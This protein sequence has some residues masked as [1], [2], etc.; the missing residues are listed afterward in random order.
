[1]NSST[2]AIMATAVAVCCV[3][4]RVAARQIRADVYASGL[5]LPGRL[6][7]GSVEPHRSVR[8]GTRRPDSRPGRRRHFRNG[9]SRTCQ[10]RSAGAV[11][12]ACLA[13][14]LRQTTAASGRFYRELH[15][16]CRQTR[17]SPASGRSTANPL[18]ADAATR[19]SISMWPGGDRGT[20]R[21]RLRTT[22]A[23]TSRSDQTAICT[24][25]SA[26]DGSP[27]TIPWQSRAESVRTLLGKMLRDRRQRARRRPGRDTDVPRD[28]SVRRRSAR[29]A[30][31]RDLGLRSCGTRG[32]TAS[33]IRARGGTGALMIADVG[34]D[35]WEEIDYEPAGRGG[36][37]YG[38]R[39][40]EGSHNNI[41]HVAACLPAIGRPNRQVQPQR[42]VFGD[43]WLRL[44]WQRTVG[45]AYR[46]RYFY[47]DF[48]A[49][50]VWSMA[51]TINGTTGEATG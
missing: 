12:E 27:A 14:L 1:M 21:S 7:A 23:G 6:R 5:S 36:R 31:A 29:P 24:S 50:R 8:R 34:Q 41:T 49:G 20:S 38:W 9:L 35:R 17:W 13:W 10:A 32:D 3:A 40:R 42:G 25:A 37:N 48:C 15:R 39:N 46:G 2:R 44:P 4:P 26:T 19:S 45:S 51:L 28:Q 11:S 18:V 22:T 16:C 43:R 30:Y 47:A 33:T